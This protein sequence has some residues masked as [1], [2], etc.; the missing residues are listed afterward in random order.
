VGRPDGRTDALLK[1]IVMKAHCDVRNG[2]G[3][4]G[5]SVLAH[6][7]KEGMDSMPARSRLS[8]PLMDGALHHRDR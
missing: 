6:P 5:R 3:S 4:F 8:I 2:A 7:R 1:E